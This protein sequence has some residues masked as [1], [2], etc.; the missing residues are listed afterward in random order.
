MAKLDEIV[1]KYIELRDTKQRLKS[2]YEAKVAKYDEALEKIEATLLRHMNELGVESVRTAAGTMYISRRTSATVADWE[3][4]FDW[5][6][7]NEEWSMLEHRA[8]KAAVQ[9]Y[10]DEHN[11]LPPGINWREERVVNIRRS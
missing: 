3:A 10:R 11:D 8:S 1:A 4:F 9:S 6:R 7:R 5:V 2:E